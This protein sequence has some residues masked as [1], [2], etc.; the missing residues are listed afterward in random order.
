M[1]ILMIGAGNIGLITALCLAEK[2][3]EVFCIDSDQSKI[4]KLTQGQCTLFEAGLDEL[5]KKQL[6]SKSIQ[7]STELKD[8][9]NQTDLIFLAVGTPNHPDGRVNLSYVE[10]AVAQIAQLSQSP[11]TVIIRST[12]PPKTNLK[13]S[14]QY[15]S[16][17]FVSSPEFLREGSAIYDFMNPDRIIVG[18]NKSEHLELFKKIFENFE[19]DKN[20]FIQMDS[21][22]AE[23]T[24][25]ASN[26]FLAARISL[27]NE[28][29]RICEITGAN[30]DMVKNGMSFDSRIGAEFL[31][32]GIGYGGSCFPK[33]IDALITYATELKENLQITKSIK[34]TNETQILT[35]IKKITSSLKSDQNHICIWGASFKPNTDD[36]REAPSLK[37]IDNLL[38][39]GFKINIYDPK[40][41]PSLQKM[42]L[43]NSRVNILNSANEAAQKTNA[44]IVSTEWAEFEKFDL[45]QL[46]NLLKNPI[47]FD[48][49]NI[50]N[51]Q[52]MKKLGFDYY[53]IGRPS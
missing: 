44:L 53:S 49:R 9:I 43:G 52:K 1:K 16:L 41:G 31:N 8:Y 23:L 21:T 4:N 32:S 7:F 11:K 24:K 17:C 18:S 37:I 12:V 6:L 14:E 29:S 33:D 5:L 45:I 28:F 3:Q 2:G 15:S 20:R 46:K 40:A 19:I 27:M 13:L 22:S 42:Y 39:K 26:I 48:G 51:P 34:D 50:F 35:F 36:L 38:G 30:I 10:T 47:V 25:Y